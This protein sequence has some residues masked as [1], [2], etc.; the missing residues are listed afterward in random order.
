[1][2][3]SQRFRMYCCYIGSN[4][5]ISFIIISISCFFRSNWTFSCLRWINYLIWQHAFSGNTIH[6][7]IH[8]QPPYLVVFPVYKG[9]MILW[10]VLQIFTQSLLIITKAQY[11]QKLTKVIDYN[12]LITITIKHITNSEANYKTKE[13]YTNYY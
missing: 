5:V 10:E 11:L 7:I 4:D 13:T 9:S 8:F 3:S 1:M 12:T 2:I 6:L